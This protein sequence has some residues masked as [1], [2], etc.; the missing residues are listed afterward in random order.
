MGTLVAAA[1]YIFENI[2]FSGIEQSSIHIF[3]LVLVIL[4]F[5][6]AI[7]LGDAAE[8]FYQSKDPQQVVIDEVLGYW[9]GVLFI[10]FSFSNAVLAFIAFRIFDII[11]PFPANSLESLSGGLGIMIDD[12]IA[13]LYTLAFMHTAVYLLNQFN[14]ILP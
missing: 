12:V 5:Y 9:I 11:K 13:G 10:P 4:L 14:I 3:N 1:L 6:P 2:I 7:K 8:K